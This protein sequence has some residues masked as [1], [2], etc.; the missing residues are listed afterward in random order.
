MAIEKSGYKIRVTFTP[1]GGSAIE[2]D[3][4]SKQLPGIA[5]DDKIDLNTDATGEIKEYAP[6]DQYELTDGVVT[7]IEDFDLVETL[8]A[9]I[10]DVGSL[11]FTSGYTSKVATFPNSWIKDVSR[12][13]VDLNGNPTVD[14]TFSLGGGTSG[15]PT[16][17]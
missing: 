5:G 9:S 13:A 14:I 12:G 10:N 7:I 16:I 1:Q 2:F 6:G 11:V 8:R 4:K 17:A 3:A 15:E